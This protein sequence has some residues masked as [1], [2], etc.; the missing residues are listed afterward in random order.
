MT[1]IYVI[2]SIPTCF[3]LSPLHE[4]PR[5]PREN[6]I[7]SKTSLPRS[8]FLDAQEDRY[9]PKITLERLLWI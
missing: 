6:I 7:R 5:N 2:V 1:S 9:V 4:V 3:A 8:R